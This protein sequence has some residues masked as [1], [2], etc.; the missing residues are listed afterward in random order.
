MLPGFVGGVDL[1]R[2]DCPRVP[3]TLGYLEAVPFGRES[4]PEGVAQVLE[5]HLTHLGR[6]QRL[7]EPAVDR[8]GAE[9]FAGEGMSEHEMFAITVLGAVQ[10]A[11]QGGRDL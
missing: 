2:P 9:D 10:M 11:A 6:S 8:R 4:R 7:L 3:S 5:A 1:R